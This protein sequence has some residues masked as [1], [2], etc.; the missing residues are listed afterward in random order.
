MY[1]P[2]V[3]GR[4]Y[5]LLAL[6]NSHPL[7]Q[8]WPDILPL[9]E[10]VNASPSACLRAATELTTA[11]C[12]IA[13]ITNPV[14]N[15][16]AGVVHDVLQH[17]TCPA[18]LRSHASVVPSLL[19]L[20]GTTVQHVQTFFTLYAGRELC[21]VHR[22]VPIDPS[23]TTTLI[24]LAQG[25][26]HAGHVATHVITDQTPTQ[27]RLAL[28][29]TSLVLLRDG[30]QR[31]PHNAAYP[32][33]SFFGDLHRTYRAQGYAGWG[34]FLTVGDVFTTGGGMPL[35]VVIHLTALQASSS[36]AW[37][38]HFISSSN[39]TTA[40]PAGKFLQAAARVA[41]YAATD[42]AFAGTAACRELL[43]YHATPHFPGLGKLKELSIRHHL[44]M[45]GAFA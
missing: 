19:V 33:A 1:L 16:R 6:R 38:R 32:P 14:A 31:Q 35:A 2:Y 27:L 5:E 7:L 29:T 21:I 42:A 22:E 28:P 39:A 8:Q 43:G 13:I 30:F 41:S 3:R 23:V 26:L 12:R 25:H 15:S 11:G 34:D 45:M 24:N 36:D 40:N 37:I 4:Q 18:A 9:V 20:T 10:P 44:Q 17:A